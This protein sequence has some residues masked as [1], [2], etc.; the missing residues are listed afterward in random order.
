M[1]ELILDARHDFSGAKTSV[2]PAELEPDRPRA[3]FAN[4]SAWGLDA[5]F[6]ETGLPPAQLN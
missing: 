4:P 1:G 5:L 3:D 6:D 2:T